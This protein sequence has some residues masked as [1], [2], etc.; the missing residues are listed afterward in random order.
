MGRRIATIRM[1]QFFAD[2]AEHLLLELLAHVFAGQSVFFEEE[3]TIGKQACRH[4]FLAEESAEDSLLVK[5][6]LA[7][8]VALQQLFYVFVVHCLFLIKN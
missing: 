2:E 3:L 4:V 6:R 8:P 7:F 5:R 1:I